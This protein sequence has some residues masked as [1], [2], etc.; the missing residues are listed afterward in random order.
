MKVDVCILNY[1]DC[2]TTS[3]L[4]SELVGYD[5]IGHIVI[6]DNNSTDDSYSVLEKLCLRDNKL[7]LIRTPR[8]G[9]YGYGNNRGIEY[10]LNNHKSGYIMI[11]NPDIHIEE[12]VIRKMAD[13]FEEDTA[14]AIAAPQ[15]FDRNGKPD[16]SGAWRLPSAAEYVLSASIIAKKILPSN[17]Y[18]R[19]FLSGKSKVF[20]DCVAGSLLMIRG[21]I[22]KDIYDENIFL[23]G[24]ETSIGIKLKEQGLKTVLLPKEHFLHIHGVSIAKSVPSSIAQHKMIMKSRLYLLK[25]YYRISSFKYVLAKIFYKYSV[26]ERWIIAYAIKIRSKLRR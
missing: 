11:C 3:K 15:M 4:A 18:S 19:R 10:L 22:A 13:T 17:N 8:N 2:D 20:A 23:Y 6:V 7:T 5:A 14:V 25:N 26:L 1:N 12:D 24:E 9:G 21:D 16:Y